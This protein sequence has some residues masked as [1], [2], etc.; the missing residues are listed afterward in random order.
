MNFDITLK[1]TLNQTNLFW[2]LL[3]QEANSKTISE[4]EIPFLGNSIEDATP[5]IV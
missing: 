2:S 3:T 1:Q 5:P 4:P